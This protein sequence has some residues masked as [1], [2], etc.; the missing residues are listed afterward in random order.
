MIEVIKVH[1]VFTERECPPIQEAVQGIA[2]RPPERC[3]YVRLYKS[4]R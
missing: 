1:N 3:V 4:E 2:G